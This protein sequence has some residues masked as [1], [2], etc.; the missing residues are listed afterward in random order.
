MAENANH[1]DLIR[2][3]ELRRCQLI[4]WPNYQGFGFQLSEASSPPCFISSI[5]CNSPSAAGGLKVRDVILSINDRDVT[6]EGLD[7]VKSAI[8]TAENTTHAVIL[9][10]MHQ[11]IYLQ[12]CNRN[13]P[14]S[15]VPMTALETPPILPDKFRGFVKL[16]P[17]LC[18]LRA[19]K[20]ENLNFGFE[21]AYG[22][23]NTGA[24]IRTIHEYSLASFS[25]L[26]QGDRIIEIN[27]NDVERIRHA[28]RP[29]WNRESRFGNLGTGISRGL[30][31]SRYE[32]SD[33]VCLSFWPI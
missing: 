31:H 9:V 20:I 18:K 16:T 10:V 4:L 5:R 30:G 27:D 24:Y 17:R 6:K 12:I 8:D 25:D 14:I 13:I 33:S 1:A 15:C 26:R 22:E 23:K 21:I 28:P 11:L 3:A 29:G 32:M 2:A 19:E 7:M